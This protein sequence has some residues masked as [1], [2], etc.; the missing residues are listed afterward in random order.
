MLHDIEEALERRRAR[1][2]EAERLEVISSLREYLVERNS[3]LFSVDELS[4]LILTDRVENNEEYL[5]WLLRVKRRVDAGVLGG[6]SS[7][8][9]EHP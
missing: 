8:I 9:R 5:N 1:T 4:K 7:V 3:S 6:K 2:A